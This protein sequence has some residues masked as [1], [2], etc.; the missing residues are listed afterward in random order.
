MSEYFS[1]IKFRDETYNNANVVGVIRKTDLYKNLMKKYNDNVLY[2]KLP[3]IRRE[4]IEK[5]K[6]E[7]L[8][9]ERSKNELAKRLN[10]DYG[11]DEELRRLVGNF[12]FER[13]RFDRIRKDFAHEGLK[14]R[15]HS[16]KD[17]LGFFVEYSKILQQTD[18]TKNLDESTNHV[19]ECVK[20]LSEVSRYF[21]LKIHNYLKEN[22]PVL[23][24]DE[25]V[26]PFVDVIKSMVMI[27]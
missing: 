20:T 7:G 25:N 14:R 15:G 12:L 18:R 1:K 3:G 24:F 19:M 27:Y 4:I 26:I 10:K 17:I 16:D 8:R 21:V 22:F 5:R 11:V 6:F 23:E 9:F 13:A 2:E